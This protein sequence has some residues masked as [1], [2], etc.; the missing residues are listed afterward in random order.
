MSRQYFGTDGIRGRVGT[1]VSPALAMQVG[2]WCG[3][4]LP[5]VRVQDAA[6]VRRIVEPAQLPHVALRGV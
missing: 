4:V 6:R 1:Q 5:A 3:L 2:F